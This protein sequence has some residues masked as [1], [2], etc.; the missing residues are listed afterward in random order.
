MARQNKQPFKNIFLNSYLKNDREN[1]N[2]DVFSRQVELNYRSY[3]PYPR[4]I[5]QSRERQNDKISN[6]IVAQTSPHNI[7]SRG[8]FAQRLGSWNRSTLIYLA[9]ALPSSKLIKYAGFMATVSL[10]H[11]I[12]FLSDLVVTK[13]HLYNINVIS[14]KNTLSTLMV[15]HSE[16]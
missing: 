10:E 5:L 14:N 2:Q 15:K 8:F 16:I 1:V 11:C 3:Y 4:K 12:V 9:V 7:L 13:T 6:P